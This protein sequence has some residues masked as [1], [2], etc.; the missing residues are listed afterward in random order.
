MQPVA[1]ETLNEQM[2]PEAPLA[3]LPQLPV[4]SPEPNEGALVTTERSGVVT[5]AR[6]PLTARVCAWIS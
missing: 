1:L 5:R 3:H 2:V 6:N 4:N